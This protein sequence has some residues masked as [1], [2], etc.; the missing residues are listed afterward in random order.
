MMQQ[1]KTA[2]LLASLSA[3]MLAAGSLFGGYQGLQI[4]LIMAL[5]MNLITYFFSASLV[6]RMYRARPL[7]RTQYAHIYSM[8]QQL[9]RTMQL[10]MPTLWIIKTPMANAFATGRN[11]SHAAVA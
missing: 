6:L 9:A 8:V 2:M 11:P 10:P 5:A 4:A 1:F 7:D 3:L